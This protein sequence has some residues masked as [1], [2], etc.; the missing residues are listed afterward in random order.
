MKDIVD[1]DSPRLI[2]PKGGH[3]RLILAAVA[4]VLI[5]VGIL[6]IPGFQSWQEHQADAAKR[7]P[8]QGAVYDIT[9]GG[10]PHQM[11]LGWSD[12]NLIV[13]ITPALPEGTTVRVAGRFGDET[14]SLNPKAPV[15]GPTAARVSPFAHHRLAI[16]VES[17]GKVL[18]SG[19][20]WAWGMPAHEH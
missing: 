13:N 10:K 8:H 9:V 12:Y 11:E 7:G 15:Y 3:R 1:S 2:R 20:E 14:L 19:T 6:S 17:Q 16:T 5:F 4:A 18:W